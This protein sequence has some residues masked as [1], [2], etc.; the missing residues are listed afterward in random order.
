MG[1]TAG[2]AATSTEAGGTAATSACSD[3]GAIRAALAKSGE[4][5]FERNGA[6]EAAA[7][8][9]MGATGTGVGAAAASTEAGGTAATSACSDTGAIRAALAKSGEIRFERNGASEAAAGSVMG[10]T[11]TGVGTAAASTEAGG[12]AATSAS[13]DF[14]VT[15]AAP[16]M[17]AE[18]RF[19]GAD[20]SPDA[21]AGF[22]VGMWSRRIGGVQHRLRAARVPPIRILQ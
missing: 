17:S 22:V 4:I 6:S 5:R 8:S 7:G 19:E 3:T 20:G 1:A 14:G 21:A 18:M 2:T 16:A 15:R 10:A 11:G 13:C 12:T 9:V